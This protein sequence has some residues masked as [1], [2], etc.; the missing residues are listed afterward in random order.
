MTTSF[1]ET[2]SIADVFPAADYAQ[3]RELV[4]Q[5]LNGA[6]FDRKLVTRTV[7][8]IDIQPVY[9][10]DDEINGD[11]PLGFP[12]LAPFVRGRTA[13]GATQSGWGLRQEYTHPDPAATNTAIREDLAGGVNS[14]HLQLDAAAAAGLDP[15][16]DE[17]G[18][19]A[20]L[21]GVMVSHVD[22]LDA[23]LDGVHLHMI[24]LSLDG[25]AAFL[26]AAAVLAALWKRR[27]VSLDEVSGA[28]NADP[29]AALA[30]AGRLPWKLEEGL[31]QLAAL[32]KW[33]TRHAPR[34][35]AVV[36]DTTPYQDAGATVTQEIAFAAATAVAYLRAM[37]EAGMSVDDAAKQIQFRFGVGTHHFLEIAKLRAARMIWSR[38]VEACGGAADAGAM[39]IHCRT[40][41]RVLTQ[42][43][44]YVNMLR[45]TVAV[46][47]AGIGGADWITSVPFDSLLRLP[48]AFS[49]RAA[50]NT[51]LVLQE[52]SHLH[53]VIDPAGGSWYLDRLTSDVADKS[54]QLFQQIESEGGM[55]AVLRSGWAGAQID[56]AWET[57]AK[58]IARRKTGI[59]GV[60]EFPNVAE[61]PLAVNA[62]DLE[63]LRRAAVQKVREVKHETGAATDLTAAEDVAAAAVAAAEAGS[64][65]GQLARGLGFQTHAAEAMT[66]LPQRRFAAAFE[67]LRD[68]C[69]AWE[70][71]H[72]QRPQVFL[73]NLGPVA[74]H[75]ARAT[76]SGN[77]FEAGGFGV[78][79]NNGFDDPQAAVEAF[80]GSG[81]KIA[82]ICSSD[83]LYEE[84]VPA[85]A[86]GLKE[87][88][89]ET[90]VLAGHPGDH[91]A[92]WRE[93]GV[94]RFIFMKC[95][96]LQ[97]LR[98]LLQQQG[99]ISMEAADDE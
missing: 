4:D 85:T 34:V 10:L 63:A 46:F 93:A 58:D 94:D 87:V 99:V 96:V 45:N 37:T 41:E 65:I 92:S 43:D 17:A 22:S 95:D 57:R 78:I 98:E 48:D 77:F 73:V 27:G 62:P 18:S 75:T 35:Q 38:V 66:A 28:F 90:V 59:T 14:I 30:R 54:W 32:A 15:D 79:T 11:D 55:A 56:A 84:L 86:A 25:G 1:P 49:R 16:Q 19:R 83:R 53:H 12:G 68:G 2:F 89:A 50:R 61:E 88:G 91:E 76:W 69:D 80:Q 8:Q 72:G 39:T 82:V 31:T 36:V 52:E 47:A 74:H 24:D 44:P 64:T 9:T 20:G 67:R 60:S 21:N 13:M 97:T 51:A 70:Q 40:A 42:R 5:A 71:Q 26:P 6:P 33:T 81:A 7:E 29:L 23:V 3:W